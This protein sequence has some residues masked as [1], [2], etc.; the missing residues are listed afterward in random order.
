MGDDKNL[1][2]IAFK[3]L[4]KYPADVEKRKDVLGR[5]FSLA[6]GRPGPALD[7]LA[8]FPF[9][10]DRHKRA[11]ILR[12][13]LSVARNENGGLYSK[14]G[15]FGDTRNYVTDSDRWLIYRQVFSA[16]CV[17]QWE[18]DDG[19]GCIHPQHKGYLIELIRN[20][21]GNEFLFLR[22]D[23]RLN[24]IWCDNVSLN[25]ERDSL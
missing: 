19:P 7:L 11:E 24:C 4:N 14:T 13:W 16:G 8:R 3:V 9:P 10:K 23:G 12:A 6:N 21:H 25:Y 5:F 20:S 15:E 18:E 22:N 2:D 1:C 17:Y